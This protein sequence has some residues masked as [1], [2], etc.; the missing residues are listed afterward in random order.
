M[1]VMQEKGW[2]NRFHMPVWWF[3]LLCAS[4]QQRTSLHIWLP[5][6]WG[7]GNK[8]QQ[9]CHQRREDSENMRQ[10]VVSLCSIRLFLLIVTP[11]PLG[12]FFFI[13]TLCLSFITCRLN[14]LY[15]FI[16]MTVQYIFVMR[17]PEGYYSC[18]G[19]SCYYQR[20]ALTV[21]FLG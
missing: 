10:T 14:L 11:P 18:W 13:I 1:S 5:G 20:S 4:L 8:A 12:C 21:R 15:Q 19:H 17:V 7:R 6:A 2:I 3:I 16:M 9:S